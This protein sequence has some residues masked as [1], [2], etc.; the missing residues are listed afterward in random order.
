MNFT[1]KEE[2]PLLSSIPEFYQ[3]VILGFCKSNET[4]KINTKSDLYNSF[5]WGNKSFTV[6]N[7]CLMSKSFLDSNFLYK[8]CTRIRWKIVN[9]CIHWSEK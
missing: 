2:F 4:N 7:Q 6:E 5:I 9:K 1:C 3:E 8:R